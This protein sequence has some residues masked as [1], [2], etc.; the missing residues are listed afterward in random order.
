MNNCMFVGYPTKMPELQ[1]TENGVSYVDFEFQVSDPK[2]KTNV[3][4]DVEAWHTG[5]DA[6]CNNYRNGQKMLLRC[7]VKNDDKDGDLIVFR[8]NEFEV[9]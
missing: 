9:L 7:S 4:I 5:A 8:I 3:F 1:K 6:I 2:S